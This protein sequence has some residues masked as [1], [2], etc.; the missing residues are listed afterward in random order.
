MSRP[1]LKIDLELLLHRQQRRPHAAETRPHRA[2]ARGRDVF[3]LDAEAEDA[4]DKL[5]SINPF[6]FG[7]G[8]EQAY[9]LNRYRPAHLDFAGSLSLSRN[10]RW[11]NPGRHLT[12]YARPWFLVMTANTGRLAVLRCWWRG[13]GWLCR[14]W[15]VGTYLS[16]QSAP[17]PNRNA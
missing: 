2:A 16:K 9:Q 10:H 8:F 3:L 4:A 6:S 14:Q 15:P 1:G 11:C 13:C 7:K 17:R 12:K 5:L